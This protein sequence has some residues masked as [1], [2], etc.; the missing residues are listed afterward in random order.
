MNGTLSSKSFNFTRPANTTQYTAGDVIGVSLTVTAAS[1]TSPIVITTSAAHGLSDGDYVTVA[2]VG[3]NTA[4]NVSA[5]VV[6]LTTTTFQLVGTIGNAAYTSGG[7]VAQWF[8][9]VPNASRPGTSGMIR[10]VKVQHSQ[11][12]STNSTFSLLFLQAPTSGSVPVPAPILDNVAYATTAGL[13]DGGGFVGKTGTI[14]VDFATTGG[15][16]GQLNDVNIPFD[17]KGSETAVYC[18]LIAVGAY[19]PASAEKFQVDVVSEWQ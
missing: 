15:T 18:T 12:T 7:T 3:G 4:A 10:T 16:S 6:A 9:I 8:R 11:S 13:V 14:T 1:N 17:L 5:K 2:S 19:T